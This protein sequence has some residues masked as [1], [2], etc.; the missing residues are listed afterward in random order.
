MSAIAFVTDADLD[1][2]SPAFLRLNR[3]IKFVRMARVVRL[4]RSVPE[5]SI[6]LKGLAI[7]SRAV[8]FAQL[9][10]IVFVYIFAIAFF[11]LLEGTDIGRYYFPDL[12]KAMLTLLFR[13]CFFEGLAELAEAMFNEHFL[14]GILLSFFVVIGPLT[15]LNLLV[16]ILVQV[17][18]TL[19][20]GEKAEGAQFYLEES[21]M[22]V[23]TALDENG[24]GM[25]DRDEFLSLLKN[26][27]VIKALSGCGLDVLTL[28]EHADMI[29]RGEESLSLKDFIS[30]TLELRGDKVATVK[31]IFDLKRMMLTEIE[32]MIETSTEFLFQPTLGKTN[33]AK[34]Q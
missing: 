24:D 21:I 33:V 31:D 34:T 2:F 19:E 16:G 11:S 10:L 28:A 27:S 12:G 8:L 6:L 17:V 15:S 7:A 13:V 9:L 5:I 26:Q 1:T 14:L 29:Y 30:E 23:F 25:L 20:A 32:G 4:L 3:V 18:Q 22:R